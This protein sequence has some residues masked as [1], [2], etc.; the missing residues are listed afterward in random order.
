LLIGQSVII[1]RYHPG[2]IGCRA[3]GVRMIPTP[4]HSGQYY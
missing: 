1:Y 4:Q 3:S 2:F